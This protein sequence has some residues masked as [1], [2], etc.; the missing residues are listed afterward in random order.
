M[1][2]LKEQGICSQRTLPMMPLRSD[3]PDQALAKHP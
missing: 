2:G 3:L 1:L